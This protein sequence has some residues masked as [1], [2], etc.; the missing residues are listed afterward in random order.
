MIKGINY[1][2]AN[3]IRR[4][5]TADV[6]TLAIEDVS[7]KKNNSI[8]Y[9]EIIAHRIG[10]IPLKTSGADEKSKIVFTFKEKGPG[11]VYASSLKTKD[12]SCKPVHPKMP[13]VKLLDKQELEFEATAILGK[14]SEHMK[15]S[16]GTVHFVQEPKIKINNKSSKFEEYKDKYPSKAFKKG[17]LDEKNILNNNLVD[18][19]E[20]IN[21]DIL[22]IEYSN[23]NFIFQVESW[24]QMSCEV[25]VKKALEIFNEQ[26]TEF[27]KLMKK[28]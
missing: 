7:F 24:G 16:P 13:I 25:M 10:L 2:Y 22:N 26:L 14:G 23:E 19:C 6:P 12:K 20:C 15:W 9:D 4:L 8:L 5:I 3:S 11:Y 18:A 1:S 28:K 17:K 27:S 21:K